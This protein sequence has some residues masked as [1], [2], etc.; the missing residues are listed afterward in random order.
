MA[1]L[2]PE[3]SAGAPTTAAGTVPMMTGVEAVCAPSRESPRVSAAG[4][5]AEVS[6]SSCGPHPGV[7][8]C[9]QASRRRRR[10]DVRGLGGLPGW[11]SIRVVLSLRPI[12]R[13]QFRNRCQA[14]H[15][16]AERT[17]WLLL[18]RVAGRRFRLAGRRG[19]GSVYRAVQKCGSEI[20]FQDVGCLRCAG[21][22]RAP[23]RDN[24]WMP[25]V[26]DGFPL[27][28]TRRGGQFS[29]PCASTLQ[30]SKSSPSEFAMISSSKLSTIGQT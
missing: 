19:R 12:C 13:C 6:P 4:R 29:W 22:S 24:S 7:R 14:A 10:R 9:Q 28:W 5:A 27:R 18:F 20:R 30:R 26:E 21:R 25:M 16:R 23:V 3:S 2:R 17:P 8:E 11:S 1:V 15:K